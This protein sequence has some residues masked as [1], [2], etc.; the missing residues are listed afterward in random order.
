MAW[1]VEL[2]LVAQKQLASFDKPI[3]EKVIA[4][5]DRIPLY[6]SPRLIGKAL[7]GELSGRWRYS[8]GDYQRAA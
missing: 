8:V 5:L 4:F 2:S 7:K 1:T 6:S 3:R